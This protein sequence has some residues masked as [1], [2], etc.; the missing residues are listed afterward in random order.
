MVQQT[1]HS[2]DGPRAHLRAS[3][4]LEPLS[5]SR[6]ENVE[7]CALLPEGAKGIL[8][9]GSIRPYKG[10]DTL[11]EAFDLVADSLPDVHLVIAGRLWEPWDKYERLMQGRSVATES[12]FD[13]TISL[14]P[15]SLDTST[16]AISSPFLTDNSNH[17]SGVAAVS[18]WHGKAYDRD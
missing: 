14:P 17:K 1:R 9:F 2:L 16:R 6:Q 10:L 12:P 13:S 4:S 3:R 7:R 18:G 11:L 5:R 8:F 15:R